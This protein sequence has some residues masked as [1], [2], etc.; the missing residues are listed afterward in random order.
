MP[1]TLAII[2]ALAICLALAALAIRK[3]RQA[4]RL[5]I[6]AVLLEEAV[7]TEPVVPGLEGRAT[8]CRPEVQDLP[9]KVRATD[10]SQAFAR[11]DRVRIIDVSGGVCIVES[12][13]QEHW[14]R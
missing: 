4:P 11:G 13:D 5:K 7:V 1:L 10:T 8:L 9:I 3:S 2:V 12:A 14:A 6:E